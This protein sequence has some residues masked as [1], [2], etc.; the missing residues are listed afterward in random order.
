MN[1]I[2]DEALKAHMQ[3]T[4]KTCIVVEMVTAETSDIEISELHVHLVHDR[5]A[6]FFKEKKRYRGYAV[7]AGEVLLPAFPLQCEENVRFWLKTFWCF[8]TVG[9]EGIKI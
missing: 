1:F 4:G 7:E 6:A 2:I 8:K 3:R 5:Q 9:Y